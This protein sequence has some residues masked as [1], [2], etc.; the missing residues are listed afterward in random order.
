VAAIGDAI[1]PGAGVGQRI[2]ETG[3]AGPL[4]VP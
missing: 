2:A 1:H 4:L 3:G